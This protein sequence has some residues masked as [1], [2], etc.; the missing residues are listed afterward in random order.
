MKDEAKRI[1]EE[2]LGLGEEDAK[3][4]LEEVGFDVEETKEAAEVPEVKAEGEAK[5]GEEVFDLEPVVKKPEPEEGE[6]PSGSDELMK[7]KEKGVDPLIE[8]LK[9]MTPQE[10]AA[11]AAKEGPEAVLKL[12]E[13]QQLE[14]DNKLQQVAMDQKKAMLDSVIQQWAKENQEIL[15]DSLIGNLAEGLDMALLKKAGYSSYLELTPAQLEEHLGQ[16]AGLLRKMKD[17]GLSGDILKKGGEAKEKEEKK[18]TKKEEAPIH[19]GDL[20]PGGGGMELSAETIERLA[21]DPLKFE[22]V[23]AKLPERKL[24][25]MLAGIS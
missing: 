8:I 3:A 6:K 22:E 7:A 21:S 5:E 10:R 25:E 16:V 24:A 20:G 9:A 17:A 19:L 13:F 2:L 12:M 11:W 1:V 18:E 4:V 14:I 23:V 15:N